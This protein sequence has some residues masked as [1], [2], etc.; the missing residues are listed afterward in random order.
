MVKIP[1]PDNGGRRCD[2]DRRIKMES[3]F[4]DEQRSDKDRRSGFDRRQSPRH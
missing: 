3:S 4:A 2:N 1:F